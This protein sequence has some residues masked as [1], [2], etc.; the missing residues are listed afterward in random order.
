MSFTVHDAQIRRDNCADCKA[1]CEEHR[2]GLIDH[3][4]PCAACPRRVWHPW[5]NCG[6]EAEQLHA[7]IAQVSPVP[8]VAP[9]APRGPSIPRRVRGYKRVGWPLVSGPA[10]HARRDACAGCVHAQPTSCRGVYACALWCHVC[11]QSGPSD[12]RMLV[13][14]TMC[15][16]GLWPAPALP[17][18]R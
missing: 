6:V 11:G 4:D 3:T 13:P 2:A 16:L 14:T 18:G 1:P 15:K 7:A 12:I 17:V 8:P 10:R 5:G 9:P